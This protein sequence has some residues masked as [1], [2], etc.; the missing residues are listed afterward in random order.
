MK[1]FCF[2]AWFFVLGGC[3]SL[4]MGWSKPSV[5]MFDAKTAH[6]QCRLEM[7]KEKFDPQQF[8]SAV[9]D[10]MESKGFRYR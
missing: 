8:D 2:F 10:C 3:S 6:A 5:S 9:S 4:P 1:K 7:R